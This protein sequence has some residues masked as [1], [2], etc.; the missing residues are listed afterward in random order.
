MAPNI[1]KCVSIATEE[2]VLQSYNS[3]FSNQ[4]S[5]F[6]IM[7]NNQLLSFCLFVCLSVARVG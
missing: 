5:P 2:C 1:G 4:L 6:V 7:Y 3:N